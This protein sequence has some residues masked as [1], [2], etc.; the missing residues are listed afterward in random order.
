MS[1][2]DWETIE[3][4]G[5]KNVG[6]VSPAQVVLASDHFLKLLDVFRPHRKVEIAKEIMASCGTKA[7]ASAAATKGAA[8]GGARG[9]AAAR[10][11]P[12]D[13]PVLVH[14]LLEIGRVAHD[15]LDSLSPD[16]ERRHVASLVCG[17]VDTV[18]FGRDVERELGVLVEC[19]AAFANLDPVLDKCVLE[20]AKLAMR[21]RA[22]VGARGGHTE[23]TLAFA[24][25]CLAFCHVTIPSVGRALRRLELLDL[26]GHV[27]LLN[28]CLPHADTFFKAAVVAIPDLPEKECLAYFGA[29]DG[30]REPHTEPRVVSFVAKLAASLVA[31]PGH[32]DH[33]PFYLVLGLL[34]ALPKY[35]HW[36]PHTGGKARAFLHVVPLLAAHAQRRLPYSAHGVE[37]NDVLYGGAPDYLEEL[38]GHLGTVV[39]AVVAQLTDLG[40][41]SPDAGGPPS[42]ARLLRRAELVLDLLNALVAHVKLDPDNDAGKFA[43]KLLAL[44]AKHKDTLALRDYYANT[45]LALDAAALAH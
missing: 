23:K 36:R 5:L 16:G 17:F 39:D 30:D 26:C 25:A 9:G 13:D 2:I 27:A 40:G 34:N 42:D 20:A 45:K 12:L 24:K 15:S 7:A 18:D 6:T 31:V 43:K 38:H 41:D 37:A 3:I 1:H 8:G 14:T 33:G 28:G 4:R 22:L 11:R 44:A 21:C 19:R 32:P 10:A 35:A 29:G